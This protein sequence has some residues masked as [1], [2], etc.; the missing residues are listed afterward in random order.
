MFKKKT[1][2]ILLS[3]ILILTFS[4]VIMAHGGPHGGSNNNDFNDNNQNFSHGPG[5]MGN[6]GSYGHGMMG[7]SFNNSWNSI[8]FQYNKMMGAMMGHGMMG[9]NHHG[10]HNRSYGMM[11]DYNQFMD[12]YGPGV[13][14]RNY[15]PESINLS[16]KEVIELSQRLVRE[17]Y[18]SRFT[19]EDMLVYTNSPYYL[20]LREKNQKKA[21][22]GLMF[23]PVRGVVYPE[24][25]PNMFWN[26]RFGMAFMMGW[27]QETAREPI[28]KK[29]ALA[30]AEEFAHNN[31]LTVKN[32]GYQ[33]SGYYS[34]Y[35]EDKN[36]PLGLVSVNSY[37]GEVWV[38]NWHGNLI[39][40]IDIEN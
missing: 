3:L 22:F 11:N 14:N 25:G 16:R 24:Y 17:R 29:T 40:I 10:G 34:F 20:V 2:P 19:I 7:S 26:Q 38:H 4:A 5:M 36:Q 37:S 31:G 9:F 15:R 32:E 1:L 8:G 21:A 35:L 30:N 12:N 33:F 18:G 28:N 23:D 27:N 6:H 13:N 39:E